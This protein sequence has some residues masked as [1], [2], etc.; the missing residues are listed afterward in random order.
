MP[1]EG[2]SGSALSAL[3]R[4]LRTML[5][6]AREAQG[7][8]DLEYLM[9]TF[10]ML[11]RAMYAI[12]KESVIEVVVALEDAARDSIMGVPWKSGIPSEQA[13][14]FAVSRRDMAD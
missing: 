1:P 4:S 9:V 12:E 6:K 8:E 14:D 2:D 11:R 13:I 7:S 3:L 10:S 5:L